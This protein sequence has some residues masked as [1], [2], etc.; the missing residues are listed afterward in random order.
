MNVKNHASPYQLHEN[1]SLTRILTSFTH[2]WYKESKNKSAA[3]GAFLWNEFGPRAVNLL[4]LP[5]ALI[6]SI[7]HVA[8]G[9]FTLT[10]GAPLNFLYN[11]RSLEEQRRFTFSGGIINLMNAKKH[12]PCAAFGIFVGILDTEAAANFF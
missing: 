9:V 7:A 1:F 4:I 10:I 3:W 11:A 5:T 12:F 8:M 2:S 6:D